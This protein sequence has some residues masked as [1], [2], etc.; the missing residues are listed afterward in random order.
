MS[1]GLQRNRLYSLSMSKF[2]VVEVYFREESRELQNA[3]DDATTLGW[4]F[5]TLS[6]YSKQVDHTNKAHAVL[7]FSK[8]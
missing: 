2:K 7:V 6:T 8:G 4:N 3:I 5:V 1:W